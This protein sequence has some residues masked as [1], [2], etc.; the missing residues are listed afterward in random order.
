MKV[1]E[2]FLSVQGESLSSGFP[3]I[4]V[5]F[6]GC[7]LR[8]SYCDTT[9][10]YEEGKKINVEEVYAEISKLHY[11]RVCITG[12]EPLL[13]SEISDLLELLRAFIVTIE[14]NGAVPL[15]NFKL[16]KNQS[17]V[18]DMKTPSSGCSDQMYFENFDILSDR[19][20]IKFVIAD[21]NDFEWSKNVIKKYHKAGV[22]TFSP[23]FGKI[24]YEE[25]INW[26]LND[27][28]DVRFQIQL[29][30]VVWDPAKRGV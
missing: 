27:R 24:A 23:V 21:R 2:I 7:N 16:Y 17:Y 26:I 6:T 30:K 28:L 29:H 19:D 12:G 20:E 15:K 5:R 8:C 4:F 11:R 1:N 9:Y 13:Q 22:I 10:A 14:T 25:L 18:M 3:T